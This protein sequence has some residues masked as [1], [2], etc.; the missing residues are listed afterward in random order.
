M[1]V[2]DIGVRTLQRDT[3]RLIQEVDQHGTTFRVTVQG[4]PTSVVLGPRSPVLNS[5]RTGRRGVS[6]EQLRCSALVRSPKSAEVL[7]AQLSEL[8]RSRDGEG[9]VGQ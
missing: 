8:E 4:R 7:A 2:A 3:S 6:L 5:D 9:Y 1:T